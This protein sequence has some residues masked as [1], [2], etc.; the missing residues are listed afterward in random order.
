MGSGIEDNILELLVYRAPNYV[1]EKAIRNHLGEHDETNFREVM[2]KLED[3][4]QIQSFLDKQ[5]EIG[6][7]THYYKMASV[8]NLPIR[9]IVRV[10][11]VDVPRIFGC[12][13]PKVMPANADEVA[14]QLAQYANSLEARFTELVNK[15]WKA[16]WA[17]IISVFTIFVGLL[18]IVFTVIPKTPPVGAVE[19]LPKYSHLLVA[20]FVNVI[21]LAVVF[22]M[23]GFV[24]RWIIKN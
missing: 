16:Y 15:Q 17:R 10:G 20:Q 2:K 7:P 1:N 19:A 6:R 9:E 3:K 22:I 12:S 5:E 23:V 4:G 18:A 11:D 24:L 14:E 21:P 13:N 8:T